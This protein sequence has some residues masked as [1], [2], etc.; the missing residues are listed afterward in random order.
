MRL[1][2]PRWV[3]TKP[4]TTKQATEPTKKKQRT[5]DPALSGGNKRFKGFRRL[6]KTKTIAKKFGLLGLW[7]LNVFNSGN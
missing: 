5:E 7:R 1:K 6:T 3:P 2:R 4:E